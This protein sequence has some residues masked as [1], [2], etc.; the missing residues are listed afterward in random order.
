M[1]SVY[2]SKLTKKTKTAST[3]NKNKTKKPP[4]LNNEFLNSVLE[5]FQFMISTSACQI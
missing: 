4:N 1:I 3:K 5:F 2:L